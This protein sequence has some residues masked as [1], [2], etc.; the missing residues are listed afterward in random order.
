MSPC[1]RAVCHVPHVGT[2]REHARASQWVCVWRM[3]PPMQE[4]HGIGPLFNGLVLDMARHMPADPVQFMI[5][6]LTMGPEMAMQVRMRAWH[7]GMQQ[8]T[9]PFQG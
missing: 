9:Q 7:P 8:R 2:P 5:D 4:K 6:S 3:R 1:K